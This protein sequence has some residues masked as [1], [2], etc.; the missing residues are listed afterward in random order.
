MAKFGDSHLTVSKSIEDGRTTVHINN[1]NDEERVRELA[2]MIGG[3]SITQK[4]LDA[5]HEMLGR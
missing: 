2:R 1:L 4:T 5:A 3:L